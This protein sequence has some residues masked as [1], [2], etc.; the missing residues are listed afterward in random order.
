[1]RTS[2][3]AFDSRKM[4]QQTLNGFISVGAASFLFLKAR[5]TKEIYK[6]KLQFC[7]VDFFKLYFYI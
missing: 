2:Y 7:D 5:F 6:I 3:I 4:I 1:M